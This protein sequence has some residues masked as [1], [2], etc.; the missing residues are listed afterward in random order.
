MTTGKINQ[1]TTFLKA[2][3]KSTTAYKHNDS[4]DREFVSL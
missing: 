1:V 3:L 2:S 4:I